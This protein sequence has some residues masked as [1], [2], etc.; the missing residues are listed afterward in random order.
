MQ[1]AKLSPALLFGF[2]LVTTACGDSMSSLN[3]TAPSALPPTSNVAATASDV[4]AD[5]MGNGPRPGNGNGNGNGNGALPA[6]ADSSIGTEP[7][8]F[9]GMIDAVGSVSITV[10][11]QV[12]TV[13][14]DTVIRHGDRLFG[15]S[16][17]RPGDRVHVRANRGSAGLVATEIK[18]QNPTNDAL[19][20]P[21]PPDPDQVV[22]VTAPDDAAMEGA[23]TG[24]FRV[25]RTGTATQ[26]AAP[27]SV[28]F[29]LAGGAGAADYAAF[30]PTVNFLA[31]EAYVD[32][33]VTPANDGVEESPE[34][35]VLSLSTG[36]GYQLGSPASASVTIADAPPPPQ[37]VSVTA[38]DNEAFEFGVDA[39][40]FLLT[41]TGTAAQ[42]AAPLSV[43][44]ALAGTAAAADYTAI[45]PTVSFAANQTSAP[46][47]VT[48]VND[49]V[50][51]SPESVVLTLAGG[52]G[53]QVG[54]PDAAT[55]TIADAP[56][57]RVSLVV[58]DD[59]AGEIANTGR[60]ELTRTGDLS[61]ELTVTVEIGG[62]ATN[63]DDYP[64]LPTTFTFAPYQEM[65]RTFV[66]PYTDNVLEL[67]PETIVI[68]LVDGADYDLGPDTVG[69]I[70]IAAR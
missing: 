20:P 48:P 60:F 63:G 13:T 4:A 7:V 11:N 65:I 62:T 58:G 64:S 52:T 45:L 12:V 3:P 34:S 38:S 32:L 9:E 50:K 5:A 61:V 6:P 67:Q 19:P 21:P 66:E 70:N 53:Y 24:S 68:T 36:S 29:T 1:M 39:G 46:V 54:S 8:A 15:L 42:L 41:R 23:D 69:V 27:L 59:D 18:V 44:F 51:E 26:L 22:T 31:N 55:V 43:N 49:R 25:T 40:Q 37:V 35:V 47:T 30:P 33:S 16:Q 2:A 28:S 14:G 57:P 17:L 56:V 10:N